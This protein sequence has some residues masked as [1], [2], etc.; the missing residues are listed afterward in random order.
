MSMPLERLL[1]ETRRVHQALAE[2][3]DASCAMLGLTAQECTLLTLLGR[4]H[5]AVDAAALARTALVPQTE[6]VD[7]LRRL[8]ERGWVRL[9]ALDVHQP[10]PRVCLSVAGRELCRRLESHEQARLQR[11]EAV[12][13]AGSL[14]TTFATLR[15]VRR[16]L[17]REGVS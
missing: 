15:S 14:Y 9:Q 5:Q 6:L 1:L 2:A 16:Q 17:Q 11:L 4:E 10:R 8:H 3:A 7:T 12:V 13:D